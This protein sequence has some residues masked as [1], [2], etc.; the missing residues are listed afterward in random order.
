MGGWVCARAV[1][2]AVVKRKIPSPCRE[3]NPRI[4]IVQCQHLGALLSSL[5]EL[6][7]NSD[8]ALCP[9]PIQNLTSEIY[10]SIFGHLVR[11]LGRGISL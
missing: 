10:E 8:Y 6:I 3:S 11:F 5:S 4:P 7:I 2:D 9:F 1:L